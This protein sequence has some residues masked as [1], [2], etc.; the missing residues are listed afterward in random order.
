MK[1]HLRC[2]ALNRSSAFTLIE[3]LVVIAI[4]AILAAILFPVF[5]QARE[6]AR[7][8]T[9]LSN[10]K[11]MGL[12]IYQYIQD[13]DET[14]PYSYFYQVVPSGT[15][16]T[17]W[18][19]II[20]PYTKSVAVFTCPS[21]QDIPGRRAFE[22]VLSVAAN[23]VLGVTGPSS[24]GGYGI[25]VNVA[26]TYFKS[27]LGEAATTPRTLADIADNAGT[28]LIAE[29]S[30]LDTSLIGSADNADPTRWNKYEYQS[31]D[32]QCQPPG[33]FR[34]SATGTYKSDYYATANA[35]YQRR[36]VARHSDGLNVSYCDGH[37]K[38]TKVTQFLGTDAGSGN[39][40]KIGYAYGD[41]KNSWDDK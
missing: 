20:Y 18:Y 27:S 38:W 21:R 33:D 7:Q 8:T 41:P 5:A 14:M 22:P 10:T 23:P 39:P 19:Q 32:F 35:N 16:Q 30:E 4:I 26:P 40:G 6:K 28:F 1:N 11:Q 15:F 13:Y 12:A 25:N 3:L 24:C 17:R 29:T 31:P 37:S 36:P 9:C 34:P 2:S